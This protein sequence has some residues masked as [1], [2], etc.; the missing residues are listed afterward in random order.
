MPASLTRY[1]GWRPRGKPVAD[2]KADTGRA[3]GN[4]GPPATEV[5][6]FSHR[7]ILSR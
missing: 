4:D 7:Y 6:K 2:G 3:A 5:D 1:G